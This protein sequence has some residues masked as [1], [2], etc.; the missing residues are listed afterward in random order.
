MTLSMGVDSE[1]PSV[2]GARLYINCKPSSGTWA[3]ALRRMTTM[4]DGNDDS[5]LQNGGILQLKELLKRKGQG[6]CLVEHM[7]PDHHMRTMR[8]ETAGFFTYRITKQFPMSQ[9][10]SGLFFESCGG[11]QRRQELAM[12]FQEAISFHEVTSA[13]VAAGLNVDIEIASSEEA[14]KKILGKNGVK[15]WYV[16]N[17]MQTGPRDANNDVSLPTSLPTLLS[18][19]KTMEKEGKCQGTE[20]AAEDTL[21]NECRTSSL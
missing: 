16:V 19:R 6:K 4:L 21:H 5:K 14:Q 17:S 13:L 8:H 15:A 2:M 3:L 18:S 1:G 10:F 9:G 7:R 12:E 20:R 11:G